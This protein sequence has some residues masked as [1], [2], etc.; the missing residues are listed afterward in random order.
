MPG[1][2]GYRFQDTRTDLVVPFAALG[3]TD[4]SATTL[5]LLGFAAETGVLK[6]WATLPERNPLNSDRAVGAQ[7]ARFAEDFGSRLDLLRAFSLPL[8]PGACPRPDGSSGAFLVADLSATP[9]GFGITEYEEPSFTTS[10]DITAFAVGDGETVTDQLNYA[11]L[12]SEPALNATAVVTADQV[13]LQD[14]PTWIDSYRWRQVLPLGDI[15]PG[16]VG[17]VAFTGTVA[18]NPRA[19]IIPS[20]V[21]SNAANVAVSL[22]A[23]RSDLTGDTVRLE[24]MRHLIDHQPPSAIEIVTPRTLIGPGLNLVLGTVRD[25]SAVPTITLDLRAPSGRTTTVPCANPTPSG[26]QWACAWDAGQGLANDSV[27]TLRARATDQL[28]HVGGWSQPVT[29]TVDVQ[30][31]SLTL[32]PAGQAALRAGP[33]SPASLG[34]AGQL[35]DTRMLSGVEV[36]RAGAGCDVGEIRLDAGTPPTTT[37]T[38][39][40]AP[41]AP[42]PIGTTSACDAGQVLTRTFTVADSF[43][44]AHVSLGLNLGLTDRRLVVAALTSPAGTAIG[45]KLPLSAS[46]RNLNVLFDDTGSQTLGNDAGDQGT[47]GDYLENVR[48]PDQP[49]ARLI[50]ET[51]RGNWTLTVCDPGSAAAT[52]PATPSVTAAPAP[53][54][55]AEPTLAATAEPAPWA[56]PAV[57]AMPV[58]GTEGPPPTLPATSVVTATLPPTPPATPMPTTTPAPIVT[59]TPT[60]MATVTSSPTSRVT[61]TSTPLPTMSLTPSPTS[62]TAPAAAGA[63]GS[64]GPAASP[65]RAVAPSPTRS[66]TG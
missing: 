23:D 33:V 28:G 22:T 29:V 43:R 25:A 11:N 34:L 15:P 57:P 53:T 9:N 60:A 42:L 59:P 54:A 46:A 12:G 51:A 47:T 62:A 26:G 20:R 4:P 40:D 56:T 37:Y 65:A 24:Q 30:P 41:P 1:G 55:T 16:G 35:R 27:Y 31:A 61:A 8:Q 14:A 45:L 3:I 7:R 19:P 17:S 39:D 66:R 18:F 49:L 5:G 13:R 21:I 48:R 10:G 63:P 44:V 2:L 58:P 52:T 32:D 38:Y 36:C 50:G 64:P 6:L